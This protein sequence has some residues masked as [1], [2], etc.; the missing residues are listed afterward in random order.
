LP[1]DALVEVG[2]L[3]ALAVVDG[4][5]LLP[6]VDGVELLPVVGELMVLLAVAELVV[7]EVDCV[8][9]DMDMICHP[10]LVNA[11]T[12]LNQET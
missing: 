4:V 9:F 11:S 8:E 12:L 6:V 7:L 3:E 2:V 5:E 10:Q 1:P